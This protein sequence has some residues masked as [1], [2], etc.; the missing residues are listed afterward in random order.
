VARGRQ[1]GRVVGAA[2]TAFAAVLLSSTPAL[3]RDTERED[4]RSLEVG[5]HHEVDVSEVELCAYD[6][7]GEVDLPDED[8]VVTAITRLW[9]QLEGS[10]VERFYGCLYLPLEVPRTPLPTGDGFEVAVAVPTLESL[11]DLGY[12]EVAVSVCAPA[13]EVEATVDPLDVAVPHRCP[14]TYR[15]AGVEPSATATVE[16]TVRASTAYLRQRASL[17]GSLLLTSLAVAGLAFLTR[18]RIAARWYGTGSFARWATGAGIGVLAGLAN[19][20]AALMSGALDGVHLRWGSVT[21]VV[22]AVVPGV[23]VLVAAL[24]TIA[25]IQR[26][27]REPRVEAEARRRGTAPPSLDELHDDVRAL[28]PPPPVEVE[29]PGVTAWGVTATPSVL[30]WTAGLGALW[31]DEA[32]PLAVAALTVATLGAVLLLVRE[33]A[34]VA[35][36]RPQTVEPSRQAALDAVVA[37]LGS[38]LRAVRQAGAGLPI[39]PEAPGLGLVIGR[40]LYLAPVLA[41][42]PPRRA[43]LAGATSASE[44]AGLASAWFGAAGLVAGA[45]LDL[46]WGD[47]AWWSALPVAVLVVATLRWWLQ[48]RGARDL[49]AALGPDQAVAAGVEAAWWLVAQEAPWRGPDERVEDGFDDD[50]GVDLDGD[51]DLDLDDDGWPDP[52]RTW[53]LTVHVWN[54]IEDEIGATPGTAIGTARRLAS[55]AASEPRT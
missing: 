35:V 24:V 28:T 23:L 46:A 13:L 1:A 16:L 12:D 21:S 2:V 22:V 49:D 5:V 40:R 27:V 52:A 20:A 10:D 9:P 38:P 18:R 31:I 50:P 25:A 53:Q 15:G 42:V 8:G 34:L 17:L 36:L 51:P 45:W 54:G 55:E 47:L 14:D 6:D 48:G 39:D 41:D 33:P 32:G 37:D 43:V 4:R 19:F 44:P 7:R 11:T 29:R 3:A 30:L 26:A